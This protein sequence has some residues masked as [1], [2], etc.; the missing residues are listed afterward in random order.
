[1][2]QIKDENF[3]NKL[4]SYILKKEVFQR[5]GYRIFGEIEQILKRNQHHAR[6]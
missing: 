1:L 4:E 5:V 6:F 2:A 3:F